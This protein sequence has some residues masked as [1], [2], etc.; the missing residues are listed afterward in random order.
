VSTLRA[1]L[2]AF[3]VALRNVDEATDLGT[4][5]DGVRAMAVLDAARASAVG[6]GVAVPVAQGVAP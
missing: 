1:E 3:A 2:T 6:G 4:V 5:A